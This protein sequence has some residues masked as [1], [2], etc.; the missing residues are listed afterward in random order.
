MFDKGHIEYR[1]DN[2]VHCHYVGHCVI[3]SICCFHE[4]ILLLLAH[5]I[6][7]RTQ[8]VGS[9]NTFDDVLIKGLI[10]ANTM[11]RN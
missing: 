9:Q 2:A 3:N 8:S 1:S 4:Y 6:P 5:V 7:P 10:F 11:I